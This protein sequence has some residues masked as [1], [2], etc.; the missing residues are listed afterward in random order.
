MT[1]S[2]G[3][4][5]GV[6]FTFTITSGK[7]TGM[8]AVN[9]TT[10]HALTLPSTAT[11]AVG[12]GTVTETLTGTSA[13]EV[14]KYSVVAGT[15]QYLVSQE[16]TTIA[17]PTTSNGHGGTNGYS[18]TLTGGAVTG[19]SQT[20]TMGTHTSTHA[21]P[22]VPAMTFSTSGGAI[23][24]TVVQGNAVETIKYVQPTAGGLY[25]VA[26][27]SSTFIP[28]GSATTA[29]SVNEYDRAKFTVAGGAVTAAQHIGPTGT[30]TTYTAD[31]HTSFKALAA[32]FVEAIHTFGTHTSYE[33]FYAGASANGV[34]TEVAHGSGT[35][36]DLVGLQAQL[37]QIPSAIGALL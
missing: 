20:M 16:T 1:G 30:A 26:A 24:E 34:Y 31:S 17:A 29:L 22:I 9:G 4:P 2:F 5:G 32:G 36:V 18:F 19:M 12:T 27:H 33:V 8:A 11:F 37:A 15:S 14:I 28:V 3:A 23:T 35:T 6:R 25:A 13:T 10:S 21:T 7:V